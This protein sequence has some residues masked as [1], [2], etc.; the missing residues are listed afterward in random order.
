MSD[1]VL[2]KKKL[3]DLVSLILTD[4]VQ[5]SDLTDNI[6]LDSYVKLSYTKLQGEVIGE[7]SFEEKINAVTGITILRYFYG[8]D[9]K[10]FR[11]EE[12]VVGTKKILWDRNFEEIQMINEIVEIMKKYYLTSQVEK[13]IC[14]LP[15][16]IRNKIEKK[17]N[18]IA[19]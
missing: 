9:K 5:P 14:A 3:D 13:F 1:R 16:S 2:L 10:V 7:I 4:G 12:E 8:L 15:C 18:E 6:F 19:S 11:I 17:Y